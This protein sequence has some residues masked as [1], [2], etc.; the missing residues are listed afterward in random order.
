MSMVGRKVFGQVDRRLRQ[1]FPHNVHHVFGGCSLMLFGDFGQLPP[2]MDLPLYT[3]ETRTDLSDQGRSAYLQF[4]KAY[5]L[6][7]VMRQAGNDPEQIQFRSTLMKLRDAEVGV[8]DWQYL[9][10]QVPTKVRDVSSFAN[11]LHLYPTVEAVV[12]HNVA[13]LRDLGQPIATIKAVHTG[14]NGAKGSPDDAGGLEAIICIANSARVMLISNL[15]VEMGLVN[16]AIGTVKAICYQNGG[17]PDLPLAVMVKFDK[18]CGPTFHDGTI[19]ITPIRHSWSSSGVQCSRLQVP[20]KLAW[21]VTIHKSQGLTLDKVVIDIGKREFSS[22]LTFVACSRVRQLQ[23][24][25]FVPAVSFQRLASLANSQR[26]AQRKAED[27][28]LMHM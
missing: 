6:N 7:Q 4:E 1:A 2:V 20:L 24:L 22:G 11:A 13:K 21:A 14:A 28:R 9:M 27:Q 12:E 3:T 26:L 19:P 25:L 18:Y 5:V 17:P 8:D 10:K 16:G 15:W 23:D